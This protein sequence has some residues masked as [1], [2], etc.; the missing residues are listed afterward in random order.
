MPPTRQPDVTVIVPVYN[1]M[2]Y[3]EATLESL[4]RQTLG[5]DRM[6]VVAVDDGS[7]DGSGELLERYA[8]RFP[9]TFV[10]MHQ[11]N[12]GGA[13]TPCNRGLDV[14]D[15]R[16][17]FFLGADDYLGDEALERLVTKA[18]EW[19]SDVIFGRMV[20]VGGRG[21][22]QGIFKETT[23]D[24][25]VLESDL[26]FSLSNTKLF[27]RGLLQEHGIHYAHD[28]RVG[29]DQPF[30]IEAVLHARRVSVLGDYTYYYAVKREDRS[31]L[32][33]SSTWQQRVSNIRA[34]MDHVAAIVPPG[35]T[36]DAFL[37]RHFVMELA[38]VL[39]DDLPDLDDAEQKAAVTAVAELA[40][41]Y[42]TEGIAHRLPP[43]RRVL[44][45]LAQTGDVTTIREVAA[46][47][48]AAPQYALEGARAFQVLPGFRDARQLPDDWFELTE[49]LRRG[50]LKDLLA[51]RHARLLDDRVHVDGTVAL[52]ADS[53]PWVRAVLQPV[54]ETGKLPLVE[55][56]QGYDGHAGEPVELAPA[57]EGGSTFHAALD[58]TGLQPGAHV[59]RLRLDVAENVYDVTVP[60]T[61]RGEPREMLLRR[62]LRATRVTVRKG[63]RGRLEL[64]AER[65]PLA[66]SA[67]G[68]LRRRT[69]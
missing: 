64:A 51:P 5:L 36:R 68:V 62:G 48:E 21:V 10:V 32:T 35:G 56:L 39:R 57:A 43:A 47:R 17:V 19:D 59:L 33:Y 45:R 22:Y 2:P 26:A 42:L 13:A 14:A 58:V 27:R 50:Q 8:E 65:V 20:G 54:P 24:L 15:G 23:K 60:F 38:Q 4:V 16:Y 12:S 30:T 49:P 28:L 44:H 29:E 55:R 9:D 6:Q 31:N 53:A 25:D 11:P 1:T 52:T 34:V 18:D 69:R 37:R 46:R 63:R 61:G 67:R 7:T 41:A 3:L 40:D 66:A